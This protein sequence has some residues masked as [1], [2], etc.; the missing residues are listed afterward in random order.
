MWIAPAQR[1]DTGTDVRI[2]AHLDTGR[3]D[4][5]R[6]AEHVPDSLTVDPG[7]GPTHRHGGFALDD[8][9]RV[10]TETGETAVVA[11]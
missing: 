9:T 7:H 6:P 3:S 5:Q 10:D 4:D 2:D 11:R 8:Q 1:T